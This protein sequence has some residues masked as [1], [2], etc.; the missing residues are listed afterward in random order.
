MHFDLWC[1]FV[2]YWSPTCFGLSCGHLQGGEN[3]NTNIAIICLNKAITYLNIAIMCLNVPV[4][5]LNIGI[6]CLN[7]SIKCLK[8]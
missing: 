2:A 6:V 4:L 1:N 5:C 7:I 8:I 3:T